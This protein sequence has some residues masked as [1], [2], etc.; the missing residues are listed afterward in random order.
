MKYWLRVALPEFHPVPS[1]VSG[2]RL[3]SASQ[4]AEGALVQDLS[5]IAR[6]TL[7][8]KER[9]IVAR[10]AA[11]ALAKYLAS[12]GISKVLEDDGDHPDRWSA[13]AGKLLGALVNLFG[14]A[15]E[16]AD[17]RGWLTL[18]GRIYLVRLPAEPGP[19][20]VEV[21]LLDGVGRPVETAALPVVTVRPGAPVFLNYRSYR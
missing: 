6:R 12:R 17:T 4:A 7:A 14:A 20:Q 16:A 3:R 5:A 15:T 9:A 21:D 19:I 10:T 11:R 1:A 8:D 2:V 18:P 13:E